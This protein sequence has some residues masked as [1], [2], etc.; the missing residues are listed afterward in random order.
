MLD[1]PLKT[2]MEPGTSPL[3]KEKHFL[4][5]PISGFFFLS[6]VFLETNELHLNMDVWNMT[7]FWGGP[8]PFS[9]A[10]CY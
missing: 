10:H 1:T 5:S 2:N 4:K 8:D 9:G 3:E 7:I 6:G